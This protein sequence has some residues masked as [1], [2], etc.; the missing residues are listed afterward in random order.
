[1]RTVQN[2]CPK[3]RSTRETTQSIVLYF[4][5]PSCQLK[6]KKYICLELI[7]KACKYKLVLQQATKDHPTSTLQTIEAVFAPMLSNLRTLVVNSYRN[8]LYQKLKLMGAGLTVAYFIKGESKSCCP[9]IFCR[10]FLLSIKF[11]FFCKSKQ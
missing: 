1:M 4:N 11:I 5:S 7:T 2:A 6:I 8:S 9:T 3:S 10:Y